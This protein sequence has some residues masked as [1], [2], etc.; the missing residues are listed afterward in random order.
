MYANLQR[1]ISLNFVFNFNIVCYFI[2]YPLFITIYQFIPFIA[3]NGIC[4]LRAIGIKHRNQSLPP[5][6]L[7][8]ALCAPLHWDIQLFITI[9]QF[10]PFIA[11]NGICY[12]RAIS[13]K[14]RNQ[15]LPQQLLW[16]LCAA[17]HWD[18][19]LYGKNIGQ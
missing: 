5:Q 15:S 18:I 7:L 8:W 17:L 10:I 6:Q 4:Y 2:L 9:Y 19:K 11:Y 3:Y 1:Q 13:I 16:A 14:Q 12:L